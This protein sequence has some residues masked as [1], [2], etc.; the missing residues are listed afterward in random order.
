M[1]INSILPTQGLV[2]EKQKS[3]QRALVTVNG[4]GNVNSH[5]H[6]DGDK[7]KVEGQP[8]YNEERSTICLINHAEYF[9]V[10]YDK[11]CKTVVDLLSP[12]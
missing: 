4:H 8:I 5:H 12:M 10:M 7:V 11:G 6:Q 1:G 3:H 2:G 9:S